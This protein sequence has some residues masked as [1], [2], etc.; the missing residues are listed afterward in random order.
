MTIDLE[1]QSASIP[2]GVTGGVAIK[3]SNMDSIPNEN[4][5]LREAYGP[6]GGARLLIPHHI[7]TLIFSKPMHKEGPFRLISYIAI[8][9]QHLDVSLFFF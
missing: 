1:R 2:T 4:D 5:V 9:I 7:D 3:V 6:P 8:V